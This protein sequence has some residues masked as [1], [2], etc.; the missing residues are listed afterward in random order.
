MYESTITCHIVSVTPPSTGWGLVSG[1][2]E[3][4]S[5][6]TDGMFPFPYNSEKERRRFDF[7]DEEEDV[8]SLK[9]ATA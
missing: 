7:L 8:A 2:T 9:L 5:A 1:N 3:A 6:A 4:G